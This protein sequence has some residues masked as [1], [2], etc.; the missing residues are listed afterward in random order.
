[1]VGSLEINPYDE[2]LKDLKT[3]SLPWRGLREDRRSTVTQK[4]STYCQMYPTSYF[5]HDT[6]YRINLYHNTN[7][8][9]RISGLQLQVH[10]FRL[11]VRI[12]F[13]TV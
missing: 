8:E 11:N 13:L 2:R 4:G 1:M 3:I 7:T 9:I 12:N 6:Q 5:L 10:W